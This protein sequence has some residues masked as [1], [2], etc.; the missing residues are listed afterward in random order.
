MNDHV[1][2]EDASRDVYDRIFGYIA[3]NDITGRIKIWTSG[4]S[5]SAAIANLLCQK[6][7]RSK[8]IASED[9]FA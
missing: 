3:E 2:F 8:Q 9:L 1:G 5:R 6:L 7:I 4:F